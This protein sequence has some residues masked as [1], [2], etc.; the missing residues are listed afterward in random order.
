MSSIPSRSPINNA[1][2]NVVCVSQITGGFINEGI[3]SEDEGSVVGNQI[4]SV[5]FSPTIY[6]VDSDVRES[7]SSSKEPLEDPFAGVEP[8]I[9]ESSEDAA[10]IKNEASSDELTGAFNDPRMDC[11]VPEEEPFTPETGESSSF[12]KEP[13]EDPFAGVELIVESSDIAAVIKNETSSEPTIAFS[14]QR[15][16]EAESFTAK[17]GSQNQSINL[18]VC[19]EDQSLCVKKRKSYSLLKYLRHQPNKQHK[20]YQDRNASARPKRLRRTSLTM[21]KRKGASR[22]RKTVQSRRHHRKHMLSKQ[23]SGNELSQDSLPLSHRVEKTMISNEYKSNVSTLNTLKKNSCKTRPIKKCQLV[24]FQ[25]T[26]DTSAKDTGCFE[27]EICGK[28]Y[29]RE[30][31]LRRHVRYECGQKEG[32]FACGFCHRKVRRR[33]NLTK[34]VRICRNRPR[35]SML[36]SLVSIR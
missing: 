34:H 10:G 21:H 17:T 3:K 33:D 1:F 16:P 13:L 27:C 14:D 12:S 36:P 19:N 5:E 32:L 11:L 28:T 31:N 29:N 18:P 15:K 8:I 20:V 23:E 9:A 7:N 4:E 26:K 30:H 25:S 35:Y 2:D 24:N 22:K 6:I